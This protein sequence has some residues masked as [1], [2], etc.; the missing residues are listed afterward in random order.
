MDKEPKTYEIN[1]FGIVVV[2]FGK[3]NHVRTSGGDLG[4]TGMR[5][6]M[7][8]MWTAKIK[9]TNIEI[10]QAATRDELLFDLKIIDTKE[11]I[12]EMIFDDIK[13]RQFKN[14]ENK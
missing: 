5:K 13:Y 1:L 11:K 2:Y 12:L 8:K 9:D 3:W 10:A 6:D 4:W 7:M 14:K